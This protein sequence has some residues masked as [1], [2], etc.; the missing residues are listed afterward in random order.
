[1]SSYTSLTNSSHSFSS[2]SPITPKEH[3]I[4]LRPLPQFPWTPEADAPAS[5]IELTQ[6][7]LPR[8]S[9]DAF[10]RSVRKLHI[11]NSEWDNE[12]LYRLLTKCHKVTEIKLEKLPKVTFE[13]CD[14][15]GVMPQV[16]VLDLQEIGI[17]DIGFLAISRLFPNLMVLHITNC[18]HLTGVGFSLVTL[19]RK[20]RA[21]CIPKSSITGT[22]LQNLLGKFTHLQ[23]LI[24][25]E[26]R[27][28]TKEEFKEMHW[29]RSLR[30]LDLQR[31]AI[32]QEGL[33]RFFNTSAT[34][35]EYD[36]RGCANLSS[37]WQTV[38]TFPEEER[39]TLSHS[40]GE[41]KTLEEEIFKMEL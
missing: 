4:P 11:T 34:S 13:P 15:I 30:K 3:Y 40:S 21:L 2:V 5:R 38:V 32:D 41:I 24:L 6:R 23:T 19:P 28:I 14:A 7:I 16:K 33:L 39:P 9:F 12:Q 10:D 22:A 27:S 29:P 31:T 37:L 25:T 35:K 26:C 17:T 36:T 18:S 20:L 8:S 1:M